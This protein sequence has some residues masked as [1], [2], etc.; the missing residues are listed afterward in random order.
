M[1]MRSYSDLNA[2]EEYTVD[3]IWFARKSLKVIFERNDTTFLNIFNLGDKGW[4]VEWRVKVR[5]DKESS[6]NVNTIVQISDD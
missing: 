6:Y 4:R 5:R 1:T 2:I 3:L